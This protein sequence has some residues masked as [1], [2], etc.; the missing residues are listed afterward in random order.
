MQS[1]ATIRVLDELLG[2]LCRSLPAYLADA[3]P[4]TSG[5]DQNQKLYAAIGHLAADQKRYARRVTHAITDLGS[6]PN[7]KY[8]PKGYAAKNDLALEYLRQEVIGQQEEDVLA[9]ERCAAQLEGIASLHSLAE[10]ISGNAKGHLD[11]L[12][13]MTNVEIKITKE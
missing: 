12:K 1:S 13:E 3:K 9:I 4:W 11:I 5:E 2:I 8:F 6:R 7:P 10:E